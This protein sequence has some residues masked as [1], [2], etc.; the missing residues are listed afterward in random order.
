MHWRSALPEVPPQC[1]A[2]LV[3]ERN[4]PPDLDLNSDDIWL[5]EEDVP[6]RPLGR[7]LMFVKSQTSSAREF[8]PT[9]NGDAEASEDAD[10][11]PKN[12]ALQPRNP[13]QTPSASKRLPSEVA[14]PAPENDAKEPKM[15]SEDNVDGNEKD[16]IVDK[17]TKRQTNNAKERMLT[18]HSSTPSD[19]GDGENC[20]DSAETIAQETAAAF[21][22]T[23]ISAAEK[24]SPTSV[25]FW[26][27]CY[28]QH[29]CLLREM[30]SNKD[31][32]L[33]EFIGK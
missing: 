15:A 26:V 27:R 2:Y 10:D 7:G 25:E 30:E 29:L 22:R 19:D 18:S 9:V 11:Q 20:D 13:A 1:Q 21:D 6:R 31:L 23:C 12:P 4:C 28:F 16:D 14:P 3:E 24:F 32:T 8:P 17:G 5:F 33:E